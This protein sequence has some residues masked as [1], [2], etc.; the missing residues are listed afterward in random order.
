MAICV[1]IPVQNRY[2]Y[3]ILYVQNDIHLQ[4]T[5]K[6]LNHMKNTAKSITTISFSFIL[7]SCD[8][9]PASKVEEFSNSGNVVD[10]AD[11]MII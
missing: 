9:K 6:Q 1:K 2:F 11:V 5:V 7:L 3:A 4:P 8:N 10:Y